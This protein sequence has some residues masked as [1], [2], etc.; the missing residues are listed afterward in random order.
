MLGSNWTL[1]IAAVTDANLD[2]GGR[3]RPLFPDE[4]SQIGRDNEIGR[5]RGGHSCR[6]LSHTLSTLLSHTYLRLIL[7]YLF[8]WTPNKTSHLNPLWQMN[9]ILN[10][11]ASL[12]PLVSSYEIQTSDYQNFDICF[13]KVA[14]TTKL[15][16][17]RS[18]SLTHL[19]QDKY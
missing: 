13:E 7:K 3:F 9:G 14:F 17:S 19:M 4:L 10:P 16:C 1:G 18:L 2:S 15:L 12:Y 11:K 5:E 8:L 6:C